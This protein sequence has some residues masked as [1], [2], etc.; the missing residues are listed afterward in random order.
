VGTIHRL[1][2]FYQTDEFNAQDIE[3]ELYTDEKEEFHLFF[4][5]NK[6]LHFS[7]KI[8]RKFSL[9][10]IFSDIAP[11]YNLKNKDLY[12]IKIIKD[13]NKGTFESKVD[14][15]Y[16]K[17][18]N[19]INYRIECIFQTLLVFL[20][21]YKDRTLIYL[22]PEQLYERFM[23]LLQKKEL[24]YDSI[25]M[26]NNIVKKYD[27]VYW[28]NYFSRVNPDLPEEG[29]IKKEKITRVIEIRR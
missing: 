28:A 6:N 8:I 24:G 27:I 25:E 10:N 2:A 14:E 17:Y 7:R 11:K 13:F 4:F 19:N 5:H 3:K 16:K 9:K 22:L 29:V 12:M 18:L 26:N 20:D 1:A 21:L 23:D 15:E